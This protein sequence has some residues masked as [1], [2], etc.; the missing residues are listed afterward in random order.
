MISACRLFT[1][2]SRKT[3]SAITLPVQRQTKKAMRSAC[4]LLLKTSKKTVSSLALGLWNRDLRRLYEAEKR[5]TA[6]LGLRLAVSAMK[7]ST[8]REKNRRLRKLNSGEKRRAADLRLALTASHEEVAAFSDGLR[9]LNDAANNQHLQMSNLDRIA[10]SATIRAA[11][12]AEEV[13]KLAA[14]RDKLQAKLDSMTNFMMHQG[15]ANS[16]LKK[17]LEVCGICPCKVLVVV[18]RV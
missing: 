15:N 18:I 12:F 16:R 6:D 4:L 2:T 10:K 11:D 1:K 17:E 5:K 8:V 13:Q 3:I 14:V 7:E 9:N